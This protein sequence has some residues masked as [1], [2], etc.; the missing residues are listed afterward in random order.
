VRIFI[1]GSRTAVAE[2]RDRLPLG[3]LL[4]P[5][6]GMGIAE[7]VASGLP[8]A[9]D[10]GGYGSSRS[11]AEAQQRVARLFPFEPFWRR[12]QT[13]EALPRR[14]RANLKFIV[15][16]DVPGKGGM[17]LTSFMAFALYLKDR[18][19]PVALVGQDKME[20]YPWYPLALSYAA[21]FFI[22]GSTEWKLGPAAAD[23]A[24]E[25]KRLGL[26]V[27][28]GRVNSVKRL[29]WAWS[30]GCD[31]VDGTGLTRFSRSALPDL[32]R[33]FYQSPDQVPLVPLFD[34]PTTRLLEGE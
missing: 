4:N 9:L 5:F 23:L 17:T 22:G 19:I 8:W 3:C 32:R 14:D 30:I 6:G 10:N 16:P 2:F 20:T 34:V 29:E 18:H 31:S 11:M 24:R 15:P 7:A 27:H 33:S 13:I 1:N 26:W 21:C 12:V 25:A 28:M